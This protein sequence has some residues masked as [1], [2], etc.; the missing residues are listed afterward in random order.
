[1]FFGPWWAPYWPLVAAVSA[2]TKSEWRAFAAP[3]DSNNIFVTHMSS[4]TDRY[5][6]VRKGYEHPEAIVKLLNTFTRLERRMDP[7]EEKVAKL[8]DFAAQLGIQ[9][10]AYYPFD[11]L[12]DYPDA[13]EKRYST[14]QQA[15]HGKI[16]PE[17]LDSDTKLIY[18][19]WMSEKEQ[20]KKDMEGWKVAIAYEYGAGVLAS[21]PMEQVR[22]VFYG[23]TVTMEAKWAKLEKL[24][25]E[26]FL[27]IIVGD[28]PLSA[29]DDF[30]EEW[31]QLGGE[32]ITNEVNQIVNHVK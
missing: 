16:D 30:V 4:A 5:L 8:D 27:N 15:L 31:K 13:I 6:V 17:T 25:N 2:D 20:P 19:Q 21:T 14:L 7:N 18:K 3:L 9:P 32:R 11:L 24:E 23:S 10:R 12:L 26:T 1:M 29:F 28:L 22:S